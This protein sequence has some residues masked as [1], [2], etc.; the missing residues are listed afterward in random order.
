MDANDFAAFARTQRAHRHFTDT[1]VDDELVTTLL[2]AATRAPSAE[3]TQPWVFVVVRDSTTRARIGELTRQLWDGGAREYEAQHLDPRIL[4]AM[5][6]SAAGGFAEAPVHVVIGGDTERCLEPVLEA[7]VWPAVQNLLLAATAAGLGS[8]LTT[9]TTFFADEL[10]TLTGL[11]QLVRPLAVVP[12]GWPT[13]P[14][15]P[16]RRRPLHEVAFAEHYGNR[17]AYKGS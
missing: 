5:D 3:N 15:G 11:P 6:H 12:L 17:R 14:L 10:R 4:S 7:S 1:P 13:A 9:L 8:A 16:N 2:D